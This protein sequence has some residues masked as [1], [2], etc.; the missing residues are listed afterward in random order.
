MNPVSLSK[1]I[2]RRYLE[3]ASLDLKKPASLFEERWA[4]GLVVALIP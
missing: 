3:E 1:P 4:I 2:V